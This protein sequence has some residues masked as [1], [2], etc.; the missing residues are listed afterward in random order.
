MSKTL[1]IAIPMAGFGTRMRPHTWSKPKPLIKVAGKTVLDYLLEQYKSVPSTFDVEYVFIVGAQGEQ[2]REYMQSVHPEKKVHIVVQEE[3]RGQSDALYQARQY[4]HG[5]MLMAFSDTLTQVDLSFLEDEQ[6]D[7]VAMV[8]RV[9]DPR[10]FGAAELDADGWVTRLIEKPEDM[11]LNLVVVGFYYFSSGEALV[12]AIV[13]QMERKIKLKGEFYLTDAINILIE[14]GARFS[15]REI[16]TWLDA[17]TPEAL[18][19]TN[20]YLLAH[21]YD[22]S[23]ENAHREGV[24]IIPPVYIHESAKIQDAVIG[25][26]VSIGANCQVKEAI[27]SDCVLDDE[28]IVSKMILKNS[29]LGKRVELTGEATSLNIGDDAWIKPA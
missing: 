3:M 14:K 27:L 29:L 8:K 1:K 19:E 15:V 11:S 5:P 6:A 2:I 7:G 18:F 23:L 26:N 13:E 17:G 4:L 9:P 21:G 20:S 25:P 24:T 10:R 22:N 12:G 16:D 28:A